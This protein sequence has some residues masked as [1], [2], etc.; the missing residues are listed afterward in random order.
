M[1]CSS[2]FR[3]R[4]STVGMG[5]LRSSEPEERRTPPQIRRR[6]PRIFEEVPP[7]SVFGAEDRRREVYSFWGAGR[8]KNRFPL[9]KRPP[10]WKKP[11]LPLA[12]SVRFSDLSSRPKFE[13]KGFVVLRGRSSNIKD[14][15]VLGSSAPKIEDGGLFFLRSRI[16]NMGGSS[17]TG[18]VFF[19]NGGC[20]I[21]G[22]EERRTPSIFDLRSADWVEDRPP[23]V[24]SIEKQRSSE[25]H[26]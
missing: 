9:R 2:F 8:T 21:F 20:S 19:E 4:R 17:K 6:P 18:G 23:V 7:S 26:H 10:S 5:V 11:P 14:R 3:I 25:S 1:G 22:F 15:G 12:S 16:S 24:R 13:E